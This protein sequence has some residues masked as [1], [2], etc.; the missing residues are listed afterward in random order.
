MT[1]E[2]RNGVNRKR[3]ETVEP[4]TRSS[5]QQR[6]QRPVQEE[7]STPQKQIWVQIRLLPIWLRVVLVLLLL[8]GAAIL[9]MMVGYGYIGDGKPMDVLK[10]ETWVHILDIINGKES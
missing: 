2:K 1:T 8:I 6:R 10:K 4:M 9:G 5:R 3:Q 7:Q